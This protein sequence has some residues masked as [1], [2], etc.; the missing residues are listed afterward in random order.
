MNHCNLD[1]GS[2]TGATWL[3]H[4]FQGG[5]L[6]I[7]KFSFYDLFIQHKGLHNEVGLYGNV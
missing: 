7:K 2:Q 3:I 4:L 6:W 1:H 5:K